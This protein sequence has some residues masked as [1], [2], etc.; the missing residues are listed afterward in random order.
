[1]ESID[2]IKDKITGLVKSHLYITISVVII[3]ILILFLS[4]KYAPKVSKMITGRSSKVNVDEDELDELIN[5]IRKKQ[6]IA[7]KR[8][9]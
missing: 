4:Y 8:R 5:S 3:I 6:A 9:R 7:M 1:M 2:A